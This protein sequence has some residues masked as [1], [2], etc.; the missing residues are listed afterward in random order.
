MFQISH[1][2]IRQKQDQRILVSDLTLNVHPG[3]KIAIIGEEGNGK[4]TLL[5]Y[6][7]DPSL[8]RDYT[9]AEG[10]RRMENEIAGYLPQQLGEAEQN[11]SVYEYLCRNDDFCMADPGF[12]AET[13]RNVRLDAGDFYRM[14]TMG[15]LSGGERLKI[16]TASLLFLRPT[17]IFL[18][19]PS[20]DLDLE[21]LDALDQFIHNCKAAVIFVSHDE[22]LLRKHAETIIHLEQ[23]KRKKEA[24]TTVSHLRY[25][26][27][28]T[29]RA[30]LF[31]KTMQ[32]AEGE[33]R[34]DA[35]RMEKYNRIRQSVEY[36]LRT[37]TRQDAHGGQ[38][39]KKK[40]KAVTSMG[41][42][43][44]KQRSE[45]T[46]IPEQEEAILVFFPKES[47]VPKGKQILDYNLPLLETPDGGKLAEN[48][49]LS[50]QGPEHIGIIGPNGAGKSTLLK[51]IA[52]Q[53]M[54][55]KDIIPAYMPQNYEDMLEM[56]KTPLEYLGGTDR[57]KTK[58]AGL[59][60]GSMKYMADEM[61]HPL[62]DLSGGQKAKV[63][64]L[65][66]VMD[67][68]QFLILDE[69]TRNFSP[70]SAPVIRK[71]LKEY[72]GAILSVSHDRLYLQEV[73]TRILKLEP[74]GLHEFRPEENEK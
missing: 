49:H 72:P 4:S 5:K 62:S 58:Q 9:E 19:E 73:C 10:T 22:I 67:Q 51:K 17:L 25:E 13:A 24:K 68:A 74:D 34:Q 31:D 6:M 33:R 53:V 15:S 50:I 45:M 36:D 42:R 28:I 39:L 23:L 35:L 55:R 12:L 7:Y 16:Q 1:L 30:D 8:T 44:D 64:F 43:F 37:I 32:K 41:K 70:L 71:C 40:M 18:D 46:D 69:P 52:D 3:E 21:S 27:Y 11:L 29:Q 47:A 48:I 56:H 38:L 61:Q 66:M 2:T 59:L 57:E 63:L 60:L 54:T 26:D 20:N 14:Q 65:K